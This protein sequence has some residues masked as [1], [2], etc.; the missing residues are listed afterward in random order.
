MQ[1]SAWL[2]NFAFHFLVLTANFGCNQF[3]I[4][5]ENVS[6][7]SSTSSTIVYKLLSTC[8]LPFLIHVVNL[9]LLLC[10]GFDLE[11]VV[12]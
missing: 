8:A 9:D 6:K 3:R 2:S 5:P 4:I 10:T 12:L 1:I 7:L 11:D